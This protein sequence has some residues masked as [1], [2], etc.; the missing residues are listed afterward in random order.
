M[1]F[2]KIFLGEEK[3]AASV[4]ETLFKRLFY[5]GM[6]KGA[7]IIKSKAPLPQQDIGNQHVHDNF[8]FTVPLSHSP[9]LLIA[10]KP[11][12]L[13]RKNIFPT[14]PGQYHGPAEASHGHRIIV[15]QV[16][17]HELQEMSYSLDG[18]RNLEFQNI[19]V[20][21]DLHMENLIDMFIYES[22]YKQ[23][24]Y[25]FI[26]Q[27]LSSLLGATILRAL[28]G[29]LNMQEKSLK[30][31]SK[32]EVNLALDFL[33]ASL[34]Q[35]FSLNEVS[36]LVGLSKYH[37]I[38]LFKKETGKTP[39]QYYIDMKIDK[40]IELIKI[41][42]YSITEICFMCG[43]KDHSHFSRVFFSKTG[44]TPTRFKELCQ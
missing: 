27:H 17:P 35:E 28:N 4:D 25:E 30:G 43:F 8:E 34:N 10:N 18:K 19:P 44:L 21:F 20:P 9:K 29:N 2:A 26:L 39:Y 40:A 7:F 22:Q 15:V 12:T 38:R 42:K 36:N 32:K 6:S 37:F 1:V 14:N 11:F 31:I 24:G 41:N 3:Y 13:P 23:A 5:A 16:A 33:H